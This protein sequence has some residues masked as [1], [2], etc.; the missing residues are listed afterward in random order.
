M[1]DKKISELNSITGSQVDDA[2]DKIAIVDS[3]A[4]ETKSITRAQL[5][6]SVSSMSI[7]GDLSVDTDTLYVDSASERVGIGTSSPRAPL[8]IRPD[9]GASDDF[10]FLV[11]QFRPNI[12]LEDLSSGTTD[13]QL[14][15]DFGDLQ[16]RY[17]DA[18]TDTKLTNE[19]MR[20]DSSGVVEIAEGTV[21]LN[22]NEINGLEV[23]IADDA[24][25]ELTFP[26]RQGGLL[27]VACNAGRGFPAL[28]RGGLIVADFGDSPQI[29]ATLYAGSDFETNDTDTLTGTTGTD[30]SVTV[31]VAGTDGTLYVENRTGST[32]TF[33]ITLL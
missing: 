2:N 9:G 12:V 11:T 26:T 18:S 22:G 1:T 17:G 25:A 19:A 4:S 7:T 28:Q 20:I 10:N 29:L 23:V 13:W 8:H 21:V 3:S 15:A 27:W 33:Q 31:G 32:G 16:F 6:S 24:V 14:F 30:G 5:M